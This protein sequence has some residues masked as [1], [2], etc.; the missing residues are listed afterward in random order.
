MMQLLSDTLEKH[1]DSQDN[2]DP[3]RNNIQDNSTNSS[4]I[5][6]CGKALVGVSI[7]WSDL[8]K[9]MESKHTVNGI[10]M[11]FESSLSLRAWSNY[12]SDI[13][14]FAPS[15]FHFYWS[16]NEFKHAFSVSLSSCSGTFAG[17]SSPLSNFSR[18]DVLVHPIETL[19]HFIIPACFTI[20]HIIT[21]TDCKLTASLSYT[22]CNVQSL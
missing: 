1:S 10:F 11:I 2:K 8:R 20:Q 6:I 5:F 9:L 15:P 17:Q 14:I 16:L 19:M 22:V 13:Q 18:M 21:L 7:L 3:T 12:I 4:S